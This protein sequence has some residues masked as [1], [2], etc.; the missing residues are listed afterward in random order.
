[1]KQLDKLKLPGSAAGLSK[2]APKH[3]RAVMKQL[4]KFEWGKRQK[5]FGLDDPVKTQ[6]T[7]DTQG[8]NTNST[9]HELEKAKCQVEQELAE[10]Q[11][12]LEEL[13]KLEDKLKRT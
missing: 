10:Q 8:T 4:D 3:G 11:T 12:R 9:A 7:T 6:G 1:M 2:E 13:E 5:P